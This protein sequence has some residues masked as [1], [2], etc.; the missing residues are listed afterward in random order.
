MEG[1]D[2]ALM[3]VALWPIP[4][5]TSVFDA[6]Q[7]RIFSDIDERAAVSPYQGD[8]RQG[9]FHPAKTLGLIN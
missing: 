9:I 5:P 1:F 7:Y 2:T 4:E 3:T 6:K 8:G